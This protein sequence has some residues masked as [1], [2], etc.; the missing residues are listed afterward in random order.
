MYKFKT[1]ERLSKLFIHCLKENRLE[2][3]IPNGYVN[4]ESFGNCYLRNDK[5]WLENVANSFNWASTSNYDLC[6]LNNCQWT[7]ILGFLNIIEF[8]DNKF[9]DL[10]ARRN[11]VPLRPDEKI[12]KYI[13]IF[14]NIKKSYNL[15]NKF[16]TL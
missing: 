1:N 6:S 3:L 13:K 9:V 2:K 7:F 16:F 5:L 15:I 10:I 12:E 4:I 8:K 11:Y 14:S